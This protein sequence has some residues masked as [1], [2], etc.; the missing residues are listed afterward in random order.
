MTES[1]PATDSND[2]LPAEIRVFVNEHGVS[3]T[4][5]ATA[6]GAVRAFSSAL[7]NDVVEGRARLTDSRGLPMVPDAGVSSGTIMR[8]VPV[9]EPLA[10]AAL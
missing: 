2:M 1:A 9:R 3:I 5:G 10:D 4:R 8:V 7:A 6:L